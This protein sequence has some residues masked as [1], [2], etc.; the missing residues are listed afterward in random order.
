MAATVWMPTIRIGHTTESSN[1]YG[2]MKSNVRLYQ[3]LR[4]Y[5]KFLGKAVCATLIPNRQPCEQPGAY[6][7]Q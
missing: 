4:E 3:A 6:G 5:A 2:E 7:P 1:E